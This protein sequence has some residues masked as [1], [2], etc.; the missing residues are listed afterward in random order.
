MEYLLCNLA[1]SVP[2]MS[3]YNRTTSVHGKSLWRSSFAVFQQPGYESFTYFDGAA[4]QLVP[5][6]VAKDIQT[7][8]LHQ[9]ANSHRGF[10]QL[11]VQ[12]TNIVEQAR[13]NVARFLNA[14]S[15]DSIIFNSG[16]TQGINFV[17]QS[18]LKPRL[19]AEHNIVISAAEHHANFLPWL[20]LCQSS[21]AHLRIANL[22]PTGEVDT[23][24]LLSLLDQD[25]AL[26][27]I[28]HVSN[29]TGKENDIKAITSAAHHYQAKVLIDGAQA[30]VSKSID[31]QNIGCDFYV[32]SGHKC[33]GGFGSGILY[34]AQALQQVMEP[35][36]LGGGIVDSVS[37]EGFTLSGGPQQF[38][39]GTRNVAGIVGL[40]SAIA[41]MD[42]EQEEKQAHLENLAG[43]LNFSLKE[44][45]FI[46]PV[47]QL[48]TSHIVSFNVDTVHSHDVA[49]WLDS[50]QIGVRAGHHCA[51]PLH[52][53]YQVKNSVR[54]SLGIY[55]DFNDIDKLVTGL[56]NV[57]RELRI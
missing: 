45:P 39:A 50:E 21:G 25:T 48:T 13:I 27:A 14:D 36:M 19:T 52:Q 56:S 28:S 49:T 20:A 32:L 43:Y 35:T 5:K 18:Y 22:L 12:S 2:K 16:T 33:F 26:V 37:Q 54:V 30:V 31:I 11:S 29:V 17:A 47:G 41:F 40:N 10:Y 38:E 1:I 9:H 15:G 23:T 55:N 42:Q 3:S 53:F 4:T 34:V 46:R 7:Y 51:Q 44:L 8:Q 24:H 6:Q 57:Y